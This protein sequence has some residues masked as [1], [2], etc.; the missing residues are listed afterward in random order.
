MVPR[1]DA[2]ANIQNVLFIAGYPE[3][4]TSYILSSSIIINFLPVMKQRAGEIKWV[5]FIP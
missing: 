4:F 1:G 3:M 2:I 5:G